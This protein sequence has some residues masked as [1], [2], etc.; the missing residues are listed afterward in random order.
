[1]KKIL[2]LILVALFVLSCCAAVAEE[3]PSWVR[4]DP[5]SIGDRIVVYSTLDDP[6]Q[7][8]VEN[9]WYKYYPNCTI[10][11]VSDSV[12]KLVARARSEANNP[13]ADVLFGGLFE[14]DGTVYHDILQPYTPTIADEL[15]KL[16]PYGY[17]S[18][19]DIQYMALVVNKDLEAE[20]G[21]TI[22][23]YQDLLN[24]ALK[25]KIIMADPAASSSAY[26]QFHTI[27]A[28][29]GDEFGDDKAWAY[30]DELIKNADGVI[31]TSSS[32]V[33]KSVISGEYVVGLTYENIVEMQITINGA[34]NIRLVYPVEGNTACASG[35]AMI[36]DCQ[37]PEAAAA[38]LDF[39]ASADYQK[40]R[41]VEN[42]ARGTNTTIKYGNYP[43]DSELG[44]KEID[45]EW[46][47]SQK[48]AL[49]EKWAD[50]WAQYAG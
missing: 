10:E 49:L 41:S 26:R 5:A 24:P 36:K 12:G 20:L 8:T 40:A 30:I 3:K 1:M 29:M 13:Q 35:A 37:R 9:I 11:W 28:L 21:I 45:W 2:S 27:L 42:C 31:T 44:L 25:G 16:D 43:D 18:F 34:D 15:S 48:E 17:Y 38:F 47:G 22:N 46:L 33:F 4:D 50:H 32:T 7:A 6:Q 19:F 14:S 23:G 39:C